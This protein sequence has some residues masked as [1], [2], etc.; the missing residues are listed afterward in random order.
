M[1]CSTAAVFFCSFLVLFVRVKSSGENRPKLVRDLGPKPIFYDVSGLDQCVIVAFVCTYVRTYDLTCVCMHACL[2][3]IHCY[4][5]K[6]IGLDNTRMFRKMQSDKSKLIFFLSLS[7]FFCMELYKF[8]WVDGWKVRTQ[9]QRVSQSVVVVVLL[10]FCWQSALPMI[11]NFLRVHQEKKD[12]EAASLFHFPFSHFSLFL[13]FLCGS[14]GVEERTW[15]CV[16]K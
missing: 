7:L 4:I 8:L 5:S 10:T 9:E 1:V 11:L 6:P 2:F 16:R 14:R 13:A 12:V 3:C 15:W